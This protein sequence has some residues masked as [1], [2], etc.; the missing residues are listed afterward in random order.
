MA[1]GKLSLLL[2][3]PLSNL[4]AQQ[5]TDKLPE[6]EV[7]SIKPVEPGQ[8]GGIDIAV[9]PGGR[10]VVTAATLLQ[11][12][13]AAYGGLEEYQVT[14]PAWIDRTR[15]N[16]EAKPPEDDYGRPPQVRAV[17]R[18]VPSISM[19]RLRALLEARFNLKAHF[20]M[21]EHTM[22]NLEVAR[23]GPKL[24]EVGNA[25]G[26]CVGWVKP[27]GI[28]GSGCSMKWLSSRL[29]ELVFETEVHDNTGLSG[30][31]DFDFS[32]APVDLTAPTAGESPG[33]PS[34]FTAIETIGLRLKAR[35]EPMKTV[36]VDRVDK[37]S[38]N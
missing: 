9:L 5:S 7:A 21:R 32:Y 30:I 24:T 1:K 12:I 34:I 20:E 3:I 19:M 11:L 35:K 17:G 28:H 10:V 14:G 16:I 22:Y 37:L 26:G 8:P 13:A 2:L 18:Q 25:P 33:T 15:Y 23:S 38:A 4:V 36:I 27:Y 31:Y 6:F 29:G